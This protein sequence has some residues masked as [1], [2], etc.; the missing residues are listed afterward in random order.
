MLNLK[1]GRLLGALVGGVTLLGLAGAPALA[2][3][4]AQ[5]PAKHKETAQPPSHEGKEKQAPKTETVKGAKV[6][7]TAPA[8]ELKDTDGKTVKLSDYKGKVV[9]LEWFNPDCPAVVAAYKAGTM[10]HAQ[11]AFKGKDVVFL[12]INSGGQGKE[13]YGVEKNA[14]KKKEW[15]MAQPIL[16]DETGA[17]G[18]AYGAT[19]T[20]HIFVVD[21]KGTLAYAGAIDDG[22][23]GKPGKTSYVEQAVN[24]VL[25]G[26]TVS[27]STTKAYGC[28]VKYGKQGA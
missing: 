22:S 6:G 28:G 26:E 12:A 7:E 10:A 13:G 3:D 1:N 5:P 27:P 15:K 20:P 9:V 8:F 25:K 2:Q 4:S 21:A 16:M 19:N 24:Q 14:D 17:T 18:H 23:F 11:E